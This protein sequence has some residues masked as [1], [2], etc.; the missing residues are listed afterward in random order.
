MLNSIA[1]ANIVFGDLPDGI[2]ASVEQGKKVLVVTSREDENNALLRLITGMEAPSSGSIELLGVNLGE[3]SR[4]TLNELRNAIGIVTSNGG[5]VSNLKLWENIILPVLFNND[6]L[7]QEVEDLALNMLKQFNFTKNPMVPPA[8][9]SLFEKRMAAFVRAAIKNPQIMIYSNCFG[10]ISL[11]ASRILA[12]MAFKFHSQS[13]DRTSV[14]LA[15]NTETVKEMSFDA[16][17]TIH[18]DSDDLQGKR[19]D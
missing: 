11:S 7:E 1:F 19:H 18:P 16:I 15:S 6:S 12:D 8:Q 14:F 17:I 2:S 5:L 9:L 4:S 13:P 3:A 10:G